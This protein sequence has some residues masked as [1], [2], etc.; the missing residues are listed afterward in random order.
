M[1]L[2]GAQCREGGWRPRGVQVSLQAGALRLGC[3]CLLR[4][5]AQLLLGLR[6]LIS[7]ARAHSQLQMQIRLVKSYDHAVLYTRLHWAML[8]CT[9]Q[10]PHARH[11]ATAGG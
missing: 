11:W 8:V 6:Q 9:V 2:G 1:P 4:S 10:W 3:A 7:D 5:R